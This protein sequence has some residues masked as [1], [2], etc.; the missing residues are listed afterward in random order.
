[1]VRHKYHEEPKKEMLFLGAVRYETCLFVVS[2][3]HAALCV[4]FVAT[5][6]SISEVH[7]AELHLSPTLQIWI[8]CWGL[9]GIFAIVAALTGWFE[10]RV[11]PLEI[12]F[13]YLLATSAILSVAGLYLAK[14]ALTCT[15]ISNDLQT[16]MQLERMGFSF[17]CGVMA[18]LWIILAGLC[19][20]MA[21]FGAWVTKRVKDKV[22]L[23]TLDTLDEATQL[24]R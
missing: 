1:M 9:L 3:L 5:A 22:R 21:C 19:V 16:K 17:T 24:L 13:Y 18:A 2:G 7:V 20:F 15:F 10:K 6:S 23:V 8:A 4:F 12:Y 14:E 11:F